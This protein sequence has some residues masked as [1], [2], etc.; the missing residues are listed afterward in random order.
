MRCRGFCKGEEGRK[1]S[2]K[3]KHKLRGNPSAIPPLDGGGIVALAPPVSHRTLSIDVICQFSDFSV[4]IFAWRCKHGGNQPSSIA[5]PEREGV[6]VD[7]VYSRLSL[8]T[9]LKFGRCAQGP[10]AREPTFRKLRS[11][12]YDAPPT[13]GPRNTPRRS[14]NDSS[15]KSQI[16][17]SNPTGKP[18]RAPA[19]ARSTNH[20]A[21]K[22]RQGKATTF[23]QQAKLP[24]S[25]RGRK[26]QSGESP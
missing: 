4:D 1:R 9:L 19:A 11:R 8:R 6:M 3:A 14:R 5:R 24:H 26:E 23:R 15:G 12:A 22:V 16:D 20:A 18:S 10:T 17:R 13:G 2:A 25:P 7:R 21:P